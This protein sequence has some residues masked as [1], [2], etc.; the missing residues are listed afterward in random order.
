MV[1]LWLV[2]NGD[3]TCKR[4]SDTQLSCTSENFS[5]LVI[6]FDGETVSSQSG[7]T[8]AYNNGVINWVAGPK[9][10]KQGKQNNNYYNLSTTN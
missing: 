1:G 8:G 9:W 4:I 3:A 6:T 2:E 7:N 5:D 10:K